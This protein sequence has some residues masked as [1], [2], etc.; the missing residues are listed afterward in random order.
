[1]KKL[2]A[3]LV[4]VAMLFAC[5]IAESK[6]EKIMFI[7]DVLEGYVESMDYMEDAKYDMEADALML[8]MILDHPKSVYDSLLESD[9]ERIRNVYASADTV[10][11]ECVEMTN[12][13][14]TTVSI[15][16]TSD[17]YPFLVCVNGTEQTWMV[18]N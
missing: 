12:L 6:Y 15:A 2:V 10:I 9:K 1:M 7:E 18:E 13:Q 11:R 3:L 4:L 14:I 17:G 8:E 16:R 5:A